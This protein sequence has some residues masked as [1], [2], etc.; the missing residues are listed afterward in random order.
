MLKL[1]QEDRRFVQDLG[2]DLR[3]ESG[4]VRTASV[5]VRDTDD[6]YG[7]P[8][9]GLPANRLKTELLAD[10]LLL[11]LQG[12]EAF[13]PGGADIRTLPP[14]FFIKRGHFFANTV[15][16]DILASGTTNAERAVDT[17]NL[18]DDLISAQ[19]LFPKRNI[20]GVNNVEALPVGVKMDI[21]DAL[22][23]IDGGRLSGANSIDVN[24]LGAG[25]EEHNI[26]VTLLPNIP[27]NKLPNNTV[28]TVD[29][30]VPKGDLPGDIIYGSASGKLDGA[31]IQKKSIPSDRIH[32]VHGSKI[33][34]KGSIP[35]SV[36]NV[37]GVV[38]TD[39]LNRALRKL[40]NRLDN[41]YAKKGHNHGP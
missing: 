25:G 21:D 36:I 9:D 16:N 3:A 1:T 31:K 22:G 19:R 34:G 17:S 7:D 11:A 18:K 2:K 6:K 37:S 26:D 8:F 32:S 4:I 15:D 30:K 20:H 39:G 12:R 23:N 35:W 14:E 41:K 27:A 38:F 33:S 24:L 13:M 29:G 10:E 28:F 5:P 40:E